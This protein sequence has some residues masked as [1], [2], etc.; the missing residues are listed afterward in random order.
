METFFFKVA[1]KVFLKFFLLGV[2]SYFSFGNG[3][4]NLLPDCTT[5]SL[6]EFFI[7]IFLLRP[8]DGVFE[9]LQI[10]I[11]LLISFSN[12]FISDAEL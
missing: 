2:N 3:F 9:T 8:T 10:T 4:L 11:G 1:E 5:N 7:N 12:Q 6:N